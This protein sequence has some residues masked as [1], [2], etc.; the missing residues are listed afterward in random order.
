[1]TL[2]AI[3]GNVEVP[4]DNVVPEV[5]ATSPEPEA[6][7]A[8]PEIAEAERLL[9]AEAVVEP[10]PSARSLDDLTE[11]ELANH[12]VV[13]GLRR[14][15][16]MSA[17]QKEA[18]RLQKEAGSNERVQK[19]LEGLLRTAAEGGGDEQELRQ[20]AAQAID[21]NQKSQK[22]EVLQ[23]FNRG[24]SAL[25]QI[26]PEYVQQAAEALNSVM[27]LPADYPQRDGLVDVAWQE[28]TKA[29]MTGAV[30]SHTASLKLSD[31]PEGSPLRA[32]I[33]AEAKARAARI[34]AAELKA[35]KIQA[36]PKIDAPPKP[37]AGVPGGGKMTL[38]EIEAMDSNQWIQLPAEQRRQMLAAARGG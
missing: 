36:Q 28:Y 38:A 14:R 37:P 1:M 27:L 34:I 16:E 20:L 25:Y 26:R 21:L 17:A 13:N 35:A 22:D 8:D 23:S 2:E 24:L 10:Q 3:E 12:P 4:A 11:E 15:W 18:A 6:E 33:D 7:A 5:E 30:A 9:E 19:Y 32:E 31:I 29:M